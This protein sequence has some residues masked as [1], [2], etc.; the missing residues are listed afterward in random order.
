MLGRLADHRFVVRSLY[1]GGPGRRGVGQ[2]VE[3]V[4]GP[5]VLGHAPQIGP[6]LKPAD[7][8]DCC[9]H[10]DEEEQNR[11]ANRPDAP[12]KDCCT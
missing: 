11:H 7:G 1:D 4:H 10:H 6:T 5:V 8:H 9:H 12:T 2:L 3:R